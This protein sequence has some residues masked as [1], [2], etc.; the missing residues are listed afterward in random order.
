MFQGSIDEQNKKSQK[1]IKSSPPK[2][3]SEIKKRELNLSG[4]MTQ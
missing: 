2:S 3:S 4:T 1:T